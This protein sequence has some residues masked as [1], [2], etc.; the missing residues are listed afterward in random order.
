MPNRSDSVP[1]GRCS[2]GRSSA[3]WAL[4]GPKAFGVSTEPVAGPTSPARWRSR[5][6]SA[7]KAMLH[8]PASAGAV[9]PRGQ[10]RLAETPS[11]LRQVL[12]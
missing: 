1:C 11:Q 6:E 10:M 12:R 7:L 9:R 8:F 3:P 4:V 5:S 2:V